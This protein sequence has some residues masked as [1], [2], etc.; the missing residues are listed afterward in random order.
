MI[1]VFALI[2]FT[3]GAIIGSFLN[4]VALRFKTGKGLDG[5]SFCFSCGKHLGFFDL[6][7]ILSFLALRG[8]CRHCKSKISIQYPL[9][10]FLTGVM[11]MLV[12]LNF[13]ESLLLLSPLVLPYYFTVFSI[14]IVI[15]IYDIRHKIVPDFFAFLF[16]L[17]SLGGLFLSYDL[18]TLFSFPGILDFLAGPILFFFFFIFWFLSSGRWMGLGDAKL[19]LGV[20]WFLGIV[21][22]SSA[23]II[24]FWAGAFV[25]I[26][27][28]LL[29]KIG[30]TKKIGLKSEIPF[31]PF[32]ILGLVFAF[33]FHPDI[34]H[35]RELIFY[36]K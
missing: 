12:F 32:I 24:A 35:L 17:F 2:F 26:V 8:R 16:A 25:S 29:S 6:V 7:P 34:L 5:R 20:G 22:G 3:F 10:E 18:K 31:A 33:F 11:F 13:E 28:I 19:A 21:E 9:V 4:V 27:L 14:L 15:A 1:Q 23:I 36:F 30:I